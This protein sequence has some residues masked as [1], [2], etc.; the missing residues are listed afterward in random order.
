MV[1]KDE[2]EVVNEVARTMDFTL[3]SYEP[4]GTK[5]KKTRVLTK[6]YL[7]KTRINMD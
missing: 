6:F 5:G 3:N 4:K 2:Q 1:R 7:T